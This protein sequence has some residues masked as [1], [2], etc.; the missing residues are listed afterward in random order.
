MFSGDLSK[1]GYVEA[2]INILIQALERLDEYDYASAQSMIAIA[3]NML[4]EL[5][6]DLDRHFEVEEMLKHVLKH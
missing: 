4:D 1:V 2:A 6:L 5:Q 3:K